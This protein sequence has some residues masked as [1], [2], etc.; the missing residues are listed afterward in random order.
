MAIPRVFVS[1]TCFDLSEVRDTLKHFIEGYGFEAVLSDHGDVFYHPDLH[2]QDSCLHE[3][4]N[5]QLFVLIIGGRF[6]GSYVVNPEKSITNAEYYAAKAEE[7]P[8]FS[9]IKRDVLESER[10]FRQKENIDKNIVFPT[11]TPAERASNIFEFISDVKRAATNNGFFPFDKSHEIVELLRKQWAGMFFDLLKNRHIATEL[12]A[13]SQVLI[14]LQNMSRKLETLVEK[15]Y[16][17]VDQKGEAEEVIKEIDRIEKAIRFF[18]EV[19]S[20]AKNHRKGGFSGFSESSAS[21]IS[22][23]SPRGMKWFEFLAK[24]PNFRIDKRNEDEIWLQYLEKGEMIMGATIPVFGKN[25]ED[26]YNNG[27]AELT[28]SERERVLNNWFRIDIKKT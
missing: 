26:Y 24:T 25:I 1:S 4:S 8:I 22:K 17:S 16:V 13:Q 12:N 20:V 11:I 28:E 10:I 27:Y 19:F 23:I 21:I 5:C 2:T 9:F 3:I 6:G 7:I 18:E 15:V 14:S